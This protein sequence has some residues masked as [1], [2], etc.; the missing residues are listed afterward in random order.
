MSGGIFIFLKKRNNSITG[1]ND[2]ID[3]EK[4]AVIGILCRVKEPPV[5]GDAEVV[6]IGVIMRVLDDKDRIIKSCI[7][8]EQGPRINHERDGSQHKEAEQGI[9]KPSLK[10]DRD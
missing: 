7:I 3:Q 8:Q 4:R 10:T 5:K 6:E 9:G 2:K 1:F